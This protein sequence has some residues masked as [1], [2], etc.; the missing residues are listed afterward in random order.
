MKDFKRW[1]SVLGP[2]FLQIGHGLQFGYP[3]CNMFGVP[4]EWVERQIQ[5]EAVD[6][7]PTV[8][9]ACEWIKLR[10]L[11]RRGNWLI[12]GVDFHLKRIRRFYWEA[13]RHPL[14]RPAG[15]EKLTLGGLSRRPCKPFPLPLLQLGVHSN[16]DEFVDWIDRP[17]RP[18]RDD[19][20]KLKDKLMQLEVV[21]FENCPQFEISVFPV[22]RKARLA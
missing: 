22:P 21:R 11:V 4:I 1:H 3:S 2:Q 16:E 20:L 14:A 5:I 8:G 17:F 19:R 18:T 12:T 10:P 6:Y 13:M 7:L 15:P 9:I